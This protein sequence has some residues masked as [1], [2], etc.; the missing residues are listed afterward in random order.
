MNLHKLILFINNLKT[1][2][3]LRYIYKLIPYFAEN[4]V[5]LKHNCQYSCL[6]NSLYKF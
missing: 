3:H 5:H 6:H 1:N 4:A 2:I